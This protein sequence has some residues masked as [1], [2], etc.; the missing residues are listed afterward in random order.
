MLMKQN[1]C[2]AVSNPSGYA[3]V[4]ESGQSNHSRRATI[5]GGGHNPKTEVD[6]EEEKRYELDG[7]RHTDQPHE[8]QDLTGKT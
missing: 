1:L 7:C 3:V 2:A 4:E 6:P 5:G 8:Y